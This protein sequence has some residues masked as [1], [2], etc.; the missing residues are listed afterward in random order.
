[1]SLTPIG[2]SQDTLAQIEPRPARAREGVVAIGASAGGLDACRKFVSAITPGSGLIYLVVQHLE[3][4]HKSLLADL[5]GVRSR[6]PVHEAVEGEPAL[7]DNVYII[8][9]HAYLTLRE[10]VLHLESPPD[11]SGARMPFDVLLKSLA[12]SDGRRSCGAILS[13]TGSD[14]SLGALAL[15]AAGGLVLVQAPM[16]AEFSGMPD[17]AIATGAV[18][19]ILSAA[20]MPAFLHTMR[21]PSGMPLPD[22]KGAGAQFDL[23]GVLDLVGARTGHEFRRYKPGT[24]TRR[25]ERRMALKGLKA[26]QS[27]A[28]VE[29]LAK[30]EAELDALASDLLINVTAFFRDPQAFAHLGEVVIPDLIRAHAPDMPLRLWVAG[31]STGEEAYSLGMVCL[32]ALEACDSA[33]SLQIFASDLDEEV[34]TKA[35]TGFFP[36]AAMEGVSEARIAR[37]F[38]RD[39]E[40]Y[41]VKPELRKTIVFSVHDLLQDPPFSRIDLISCRNVLIYFKPEAQ[42]RILAIFHFALQP[43]GQLV[44]GASETATGAEKL[45]ATT[46]HPFRVYRRLGR[47][48]AFSEK[49]A[50]FQLSLG[51][52]P[53]IAVSGAEGTGIKNR[54]MELCRKLVLEAY[55]PPAVLVTRGLE[56][57]YA[58][59]DLD[60]FLRIPAGEP[61]TD[62]LAMAREGVRAKL[63]TAVQEALRN[64]KKTSLVLS[65]QQSD[66]RLG[67]VRIEA[68]PVRDGADILVL[69]C[70]LSGP[71]AS[72][73][74]PIKANALASLEPEASPLENELEETRSELQAAIRNLETLTSEQK[75]VN[76]EA[77]SVQEEYQSTNEELLTSKEELQSLN[78]EQ[79]ALNT[80]LHEA[81]EREKR[82]SS[83]LQNVLY[84]TNVATLFLDLE[85]K[86]QF[87]TPATKSLFNLIPSDIGRPLADLKGLPTDDTLLEDA[88]LVLSGLDSIERDIEAAGSVWFQRRIFPYVATDK[89][90][91][92]VV[93]TW[94]DTSE[95]RLAN[96]AVAAARTEAELA[97]Q[98]KSRFLAAASHDLRQ[99]L[100]TL[101]LLQGLLS[102]TVST[103]PERRLVT[104]FEETVGAMT[105]MLNT[106]LDINQMEEGAIRAETSTFGVGEI[107]MRLADE[108]TYH[109]HAKRLALKVVGTQMDVVSDPRLLEQI[110]R[111]LVSN[112]LKYT[113]SGKVLIGCRR[114]GTC[115]RIE[116]W[117]TGIGI[118]KAALS[119]IFEEYHQIGNEARERSKGMGLGLSIVQRLSALLGHKIEVRSSLGKGSVFSLLVPIGE[120]SSNLPPAPSFVREPAPPRK[121]R[122]SILVV[123]DDA[124]VQ[125]LMA[126]LL[127]GDGHHVKTASN[128]LRAL[129]EMRHGSFK[130]DLV[131]LDYNL[132][133]GMDGLETYRR[134]KLLMN[135]APGILMLTGDISARARARISDAEAPHLSK[136]VKA[137]AVLALV[138]SLLVQREAQRETAPQVGTGNAPALATIFIVDDDAY[139][140]DGLREILEAE[141]RQVADFASC[142]AFLEGAHPRPGDMLLLD[143]SLPGMNGIGLL[144]RLTELEKS[145]PTIVI[146]G[147][148]DLTVAVKVMKAG[149]LDLIEK[150]I[151]RE[152]LLAA[153]DRTLNLSREA[154]DLSAWRHDAARQ[155]SG[156][157]HRQREVMTMVLAGHPSKN[158]AADLGIS[159]RTVE[160]HRAS[161]M[162]RTGSK[163]LPALARLAMVAAEAQT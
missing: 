118:P 32:E 66:G 144:H 22:A 78:E 104:R 93:V 92:G 31:C 15:K 160:N 65:Q 142:E 74:A 21:F 95:Q 121:L 85:L 68:T 133:H 116:I 38:Q 14:G 61:S 113:E 55:S 139:L 49:R 80:Q 43:E 103:A 73:L 96:R 47:A 36:K 4:N 3:P 11:Q 67:E 115:L 29:L 126:Q 153:I 146:T 16:E 120:A 9:P 13:G 97:T 131:I 24:L 150:P 91:D 2:N 90:V 158:I 122:A 128:G 112:A 50:P 63:R 72:R 140:R 44:L 35:R 125:A 129:E 101:A 12:A 81:L 58:L 37:F 161:I 19:Q 111:N 10:G 155:I 7:P 59:G 60:P 76:E 82:V 151:G 70:F 94:A 84:S 69:V 132:P 71:E 79:I 162:R 1:M 106:L 89:S 149:A 159:Q 62:L 117:D 33:I 119:A 114:A 147:E 156:L 45:F 56:C 148:H 88:R 145:L 40:G 5:L 154:K 20:E 163:S 110:L 98:A 105:G 53:R 109:A 77:L 100:Q 130:P 123:E 107:L 8:P 83:D 41:R 108:F 28:Y 27:A 51:A 143:A 136:P 39:A 134:L 26:G 157:T 18:D 34:L 17:S 152:D 102:K 57:V 75:A 99:P 25:I 87:F 135:Y 127:E 141:G 6:V 46:S 52:A 124:D 138:Q 64:G 48:D 23:N 30:D 54:Y 86:I 137:E 42:A